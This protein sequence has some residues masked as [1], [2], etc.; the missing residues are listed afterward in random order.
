[1]EVRWAAKVSRE[2]IQRLYR[3]DA[4]GILDEELIDEVGWALW[5]RCDSILTVTAAHYGRMVCPGCGAAFD[6]GGPWRDDEVI[7]CA[8]CGWQLPWP[9]YHQTYRGKQLFGINA[10]A[11]FELYQRD[12][13]RAQAANLKMALIDQLIHGFHQGLREI[14]RPAAA[15]LITGS[16]KEVIRFLDGLTNG[17]VSAA[18]LGDSREEWRRT[19]ASADWSRTF[20]DPDPA[21]PDQAE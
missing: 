12:F 18:G 5:S 4:S 16:M 15:N 10:L 8:G 6:H 17:A 21:L 19:L 13:P 14:G 20:I 3:A 11:V 2:S 9:S 1:M 7:L